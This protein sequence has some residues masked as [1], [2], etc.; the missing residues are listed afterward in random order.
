LSHR[1][2]RS[3][4]FRLRKLGCLVVQEGWLTST[5]MALRV[6]EKGVLAAIGLEPGEL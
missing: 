3:A 1:A 2:V 6:T 5:H 4:M